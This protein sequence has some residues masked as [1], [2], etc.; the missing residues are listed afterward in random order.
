MQP[1]SASKILHSRAFR[2][3]VTAVLTAVLLVYVVDVRA[4]LRAIRGLDVGWALITVLVVS[5]DR[6]L[7]A[8]KWRML[9]RA[10]GGA[11]GVM[12]CIQIYCAAMVWGLAL[13][14]TVG[15]DAIRATI[16][17][18]RGTPLVDAVASILIER[19]VGFVAALLW[20]LLGLFLLNE[21]LPDSHGL[22]RALWP[23]ALMSLVAMSFLVA[24]L[25]RE[26]FNALIRWIPRRIAQ[27]SFVRRFELLH[28]AYRDL[29]T[30]RATM[31]AFTALTLIQ[32]ITG[33]A[34]TVSTAAALH[35]HA[36]IMAMIAAVPLAFVAARL[37]IS[38]D[39]IG[40]FESIFIGIMSLAGVA[41]ADALAI[42]LV[43]RVLQIVAWF[44]WWLAF[45]LSS[46]SMT[47]PT[48][49]QAPEVAV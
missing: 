11:A 17:A 7:N 21:F 43:S 47:P 24:S 22:Q 2:I 46:G 6:A 35:V 26:F 34:I 48:Q 16:V 14:S 38:L 3:A 36:N 8:Y 28:R 30:T 27:H 33:I 40:V 25:H 31:S 13:P 4:A 39:G 49:S 18:R 42:A 29:G 32:P 5:I 9:L 10:R 20:A 37:P 23:L 15:A 45:V 19:G 41:P 44:P 1:R 12:E